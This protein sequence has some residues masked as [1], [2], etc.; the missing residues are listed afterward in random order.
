MNM[1][2]RI[3]ILGATGSVG[4]TVLEEIARH[5]EQFEVLGI[6]CHSNVERAER[7]IKNFSVQA[8]AVTNPKIAVPKN[9][10]G[11]IF[12]GTDGLNALVESLEFDALVVATAG[13]DGLRPVLRT[14]DRGKTVIL[15][16]KEILVVAGDMVMNLAQSRGVTV[17]PLDSEHHAIFQ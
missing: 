6:S 5:G 1:K 9:L 12:R 15:A 11:K 14:I 13:I 10:C 3:V 16:S 2:K 8:M 17:L 4:T 7:I